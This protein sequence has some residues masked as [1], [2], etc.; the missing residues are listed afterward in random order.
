MHHDTHENQPNQSA[1]PVGLTPGQ[2]APISME[3]IRAKLA[4]STGREYWRGLDEIAETEDFQ[5]WLEDE[6]PNRSTLLQL[7]RRDFL[8]IMGASMAM[9]G[10]V[11]CRN[12]PQDKIVPYVKQPEEMTL[13]KPLI[14]A[15]TAT[16][17]GYGRGLLVSSREGRP[18]KLEGNPDHPASAFP[19]DGLKY[20]SSDAI[21]Q[22]SLLELYDPDRLQNTTRDGNI[23]TFADFLAD[24]Q[25][26][27]TAAKADAGQPIRILTETVTSP[28][29]AAQLKAIQTANPRVK[30]HQ[31]EP[32]GNSIRLGAKLA[33][34]EA[35]NTIY[36]FDKADRVLALDGDFFM[37]LPGSVRYSREYAHHRR[38]NKNKSTMS[39]LY[40]VES[41]PTLTGA[42][43]DH[44]LRARASDIE[45][46]ARAILA[47][48]EGK[49]DP[50][51]AGTEGFLK[52]CFEDLK[53]AGANALV[54]VGDGQP[55]IVHAIGHKI[56]SALGVVGNTVTYIA[57]VETVADS[58]DHFA[59]LKSLVTDM[60]AGSVKALFIFGANPAYTA[61]SDVEFAKA[62]AKVP[63]RARI[64]NSVDETAKLCNWNVPTTHFLEA[65][66]DIRAYDGTASVV[67][68]LIMPL[69]EGHSTIEVLAGI[70]GKPLGGLDLVRNYWKA[71]NLDPNFEKAW[72]K[73]LN[74][75]VIAGTAFPVKTV[76]ASGAIPAAT[77]VNT[78][79][80]IIFR[81]DP[82]V[83][84][85]RHAN[86]GWLQELPKPITKLTWDNAAIISPKMAETSG[87]SQGDILEISAKNK[88]VK[89][90]VWVQPGHPDNSISLHFGYGRESAG[91]TGDGV[92]FNAYKIWTSES[93]EVMSGAT[94]RK[95][96]DT[97]RLVTTQ[98]QWA[99][100][101]RDM[102]RFKS[103]EKWKEEK[104]SEP[105]AEEPPAEEDGV[106]TMFDQT[107]EWS[108]GFVQWGMSIDMTTC[109]GCNACAVACQSE[110]NIPVVGKEQVANGRH[111]NWIRIDRYYVT[112][113]SAGHT[114][115]DPLTLFQPVPCMHCEKAPCEPV[116]PVGATVHS[117]EGL[118]QMVYNRCVGTRYCSNNCPY[119]VRR[120]NFLN[121]ANHHETPVLKLLNNPDVTVRGRGVM[122]KCT[123]CTQRLS[124]SRIEAKNKNEE[125][126]GSGVM[127]A[128][129]QA[130]PTHAISFG[131]I[132][133]P[134][135]EVS[136]W[137]A[138][139]ANYGLLS[140]L[141]T[142]P[143]TTY[144]ERVNNP[145]PAL[146]K[147]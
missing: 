36:H 80:E 3:A 144:L 88:S 117:H 138:E 133:D 127:T 114:V 132:S 28:T 52:A 98:T 41:A 123:Y 84:D 12:L 119:K 85:G 124:A 143:R 14:F 100:E 93:P 71:Q 92:G 40:A 13:G 99:M 22:A 42:N 34:G 142:T 15:T 76:A 4:A 30:W 47:M 16:I 70:F 95:T 54:V 58:E 72:E 65:W 145:N 43:A 27:I 6:F 122:E 19:G 50:A 24:A 115:D 129:Q 25:A 7:D 49:S 48:A 106:P 136:K 109:I 67:Q 8:K 141:N 23:A 51:P 128:C 147:A 87:Y 120:F 56:N 107:K 10:L 75:G 66:G 68:P 26:I 134:K 118:N 17:N 39:R 64:G 125:Y 55:A 146:E 104:Q 140:E 62:L 63:L 57:P 81:N 78:G 61:P 38:V 53:S 44:R 79:L 139:K 131:N 126:D 2:D 90:P 102:V 103:L 113:A 130:C 135:S 45:A 18:V 46:I 89:A 97:Y 112:E 121:W 83:G 110:N 105:L 116:C 108:P 1:K 20:G 91:H 137:K 31:Y 101:G 59:S 33:F 9:A 21:T 77:P 82:T 86:N 37:N 96:G 94:I 29:M 11:G 74:N 111:M 60:A 5:L 35:V 73:W 69:Y 32:V